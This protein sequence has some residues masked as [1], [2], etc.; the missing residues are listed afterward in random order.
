[1]T[2]PAEVTRRVTLTRVLCAALIVGEVVRVLQIAPRWIAGSPP[3]FPGQYESRL[4]NAVVGV[5][6]LGAVLVGQSAGR[7]TTRGRIAYW[8]L[9][10]VACVVV[11]GQ[12][13]TDR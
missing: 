2:A 13:I 12:M 6:I 4:L 10:G 3:A 7:H 5:G 1:M 11:A 9:L 8:G